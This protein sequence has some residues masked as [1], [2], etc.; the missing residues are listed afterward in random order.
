MKKV[1]IP[2][3]L[4]KVSREILTANGNYEVVQ[5]ESEDLEGL[6]KANPDAYAIIVRSNK[7][8]P[9]IID[10]LPQLKVIVRA[11]AGYNTID[12]KYA[13]EKGID[14]MNT[15]GAN[16][17]AVAEEVIALMLADARHVVQ[18]DPSVRSGKWEKK[19]FM[20]REISY[21]TVGIIGLG[22][23]GQLVAK[24]LSGFDVKLLGYDPVISSQRAEE[25]GVELTDVETIFSQSDYVTLHIPE[26]D[27]TRQM[28]NAKLLSL[29]KDGATLINTARS[30]IID[31]EAV[32]EARKTKNIRFLNDVYPKDAEGEKSVAK[33][34]DVMLPHLGASTKESNFNAAKRAAEQIIDL[35]EKGI[36]S[37]IV[38]RAI[39]EGLDEA[40]CDLT[41]TLARLC[42]SMVGRDATPKTIETSFYGALAP[43]ADWLLVPIVAGIWDDFDRSLD[44]QAARKYLKD[45]GISYVDREV[46]NQ[47]GYGNSITVDMTAD[48]G[49]SGL[50]NVSIRGTIAEGVTMVSRIDEFQKLYFEPVGPTAVFLYEDRPGVLGTIGSKLAESGINIEDVRNPH[51]PK[52]NRSLA[53]LKVNKPVSGELANDIGKT[54]DARA[55]FSIVL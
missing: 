10:T 36:T 55:A 39:P 24:R 23:I 28:A 45:M 15:P 17:N 9:E 44:F 53:I 29:M 35:D 22:H 12:T 37:F 20:G 48:T 11:G 27:E 30:G 6:A 49:T 40:Y 5:E 16:S 41:N 38:N 47:K 43:F 51:D 34:S 3:K 26:T 19:K 7:V 42:R 2:T 4:D 14:V 46:D 8:T 13:R 33:I 54:I 31:E 25:L 32:E 21:K 52:T 50:R 18:G 1:L